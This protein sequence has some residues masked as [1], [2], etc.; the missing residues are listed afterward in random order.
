MNAAIL[1][2][3]SPEML[4]LMQQLNPGAK[5]ATTTPA[6]AVTSRE[7]LGK[8]FIA[9]QVKS[10]SGTKLTILRPDKQTQEIAVD[11]NTSF[12]KGNESI[13]LLDIKA[14]DFVFGPGT[15]QNGTFV[16][17]QLNVGQPAGTAPDHSAG[18]SS[19][20]ADASK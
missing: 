17:K 13:T 2:V 16:P 11:E 5:P 8:K 9:G 14:E 4:Q 3:M 19:K 10:I 15:V 1:V 20:P 6:G 18:D 12:K 7:D